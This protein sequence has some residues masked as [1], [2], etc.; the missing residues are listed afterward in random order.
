M[1][2]AK[3]LLSEHLIQQIE[4]CARQQGRKPVEVLEEAIVRYMASLSLERLAERGEAMRKGVR[5]ED[6]PDL[7][8]QHRHEKRGR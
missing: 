8:H 2:D 5:E 6:I 4:A 3:E 7:V 1:T